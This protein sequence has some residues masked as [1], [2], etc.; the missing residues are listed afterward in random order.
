MRLAFCL[1]IA[2]MT[3][4]TSAQAKSKAATNRFDGRLITYQQFMRLSSDA[5]RA[6]L[7]ELQDILVTLEQNQTR[8]QIA[9]HDPTA[10]KLK[11]QIAAFLKMAEFLPSAAAETVGPVNAGQRRL[12]IPRWNSTDGKWTC[13]PAPPYSFD[14]TLGT[15]IIQYERR[16]EM[17]SDWTSG[18]PANT[19]EVRNR[20]VPTARCI[21][22]E[23]WKALSRSR[24]KE[25]RTGVRFSP[26]FFDGEDSDF[27]RKYTHGGG[28][29]E[30]D[31][32]AV[33][34]GPGLADTDATA[35]P[36]P[37]ESPKGGEPQAPQ[38]SPG[39]VSGPVVQQPQPQAPIAEPPPAPV[40]RFEKLQ[41]EAMDSAKKKQA[42]EAF[43]R[44]TGADTCV[45]GGFFTK[46]SNTPARGKGSCELM[47][48]MKV[49]PANDANPNGVM[50]T[51]SKDPETGKEAAMCNPTVFCLGLK[52]TPNVRKKMLDQ[53]NG[54]RRKAMETDLATAAARKPVNKRTGKRPPLTEAE[55]KKIQDRYAL[56]TDQQLDGLYK[57]VEGTDD[58]VLTMTFCAPISQ[59]LTKTCDTR[60]QEHLDGK[61]GPPG[62]IGQGFEY[63]QCDPA[64]IKG[65]PLQDE[66]N[67]LAE[68]TYKLYKKQC[69]AESNASFRGLFCEECNLLGERIFKA[70]QKAVGTG[71]TDTGSGT[72]QQGQP[73]NGT[74]TREAGNGVFQDE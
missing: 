26:D 1:V 23:S 32:S 8:Y 35:G 25:I 48:A 15:C 42:I 51:C 49:G 28:V 9:S 71:C 69:G 58:K 31:G 41:C 43:R 61:R 50:N 38:S 20:D 39:D 27:G 72:P 40:C 59:E 29:Y 52:A 6:Y 5:R 55:K 14:P 56:V 11:E 54:D 10:W 37:G 13:D 63:V 36:K 16:G 64:K 30:N 73:G 34:G 66:W 7:T 67:K 3:W 46:K 60:L 45:A 2:L 44:D 17:L 19:Q 21:P 70:N 68:D 33:A 12:A 4:A 65:F 53:I 47:K 18:C 22:I 62:F 57:T 24:Q 74:A